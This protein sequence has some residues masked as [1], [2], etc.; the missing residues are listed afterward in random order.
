MDSYSIIKKP[1]LSEKGSLMKEQGNY[2]LFAVAREATKSQIKKAVEEIFKVHVLKVNTITLPGK[3]KRFGRSI[4]EAKKFKK[5]AVKIK[6]D[7]KIEIV[8]GV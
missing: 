4:S 8:E 2:Y 5:A 3:S 6:A 1:M 7:E